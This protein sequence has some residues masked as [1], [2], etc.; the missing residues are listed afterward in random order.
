M[1][2]AKKK[3]TEI[4]ELKEKLITA[5]K[6]HLNKGIECVNTHEMGEVVDMIKDLCEAEEK[7]YKSCYYKTVVEAM[8]EEKEEEEL[9][10]K[11]GLTGMGEMDEM[12]P[13]GYSRS[14][15]GTPSRRMGYD[16]WRYNSGRFAPTGHGHRS[17]YHD[18][19]QI[20]QWMHEDAFPDDPWAKYGYRSGRGGSNS[21]RSGGS[22]EGSGNGSSSGSM[23]SN[24]RMGYTGSERGH[25]Y[26]RYNKARMGY[27]ES[28][29]AAHKE[30]MD[31]SAREYVVDIAESVKE[32]WKDADPAMRKEIKNKFLSLTNEM[33]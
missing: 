20:E 12:G 8:K 4:C 16:H 21:G 29:D 2:E 23:G 25:R 27:H 19:E 31:A 26:D 32:I 33:V 30:H 18:P 3:A 7:I 24:G 17:G 15:R 5:A 6:E 9:L 28:G 14:V 1:E 13:M 11:M 22:S 10:A